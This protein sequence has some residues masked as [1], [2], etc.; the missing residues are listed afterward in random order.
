MMAGSK[1]KVLLIIDDEVF[2]HKALKRH[3]R[4]SFAKILSA[5]TPA[6]VEA[7][8][9]EHQ[10][11]HMLCDCFLGPDIPLGIEL[12]PGWVKKQPSV[13]RVVVFSG[14]SFKMSDVPPEV[15]MVVPKA[16]DLEVLMDALAIEEKS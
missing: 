4:S 7:L 12:I 3:L 8:L 14:S 11:T 13:E 9:K 16:D 2:I 1:E 5:H 10:V 15:D 6:E